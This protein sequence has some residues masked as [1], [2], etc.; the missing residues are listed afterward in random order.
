[1]AKKDYVVGEEVARR[2]GSRERVS[3]ARFSSSLATLA[4]EEAISMQISCKG[5]PCISSGALAFQALLCFSANPGTF[6]LLW[7]DPAQNLLAID[8]GHRQKWLFTVMINGKAAL[9]PQDA[10]LA[11]R[12]S[13]FLTVIPK[14]HF[15][16][17]Q[18]LFRLAGLRWKV[19]TVHD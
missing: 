5:L 7:H 2:E 11:N 16:T 18:Q 12:Y 19:N 10:M 6:R 13:Y 9:E 4:A 15:I 8:L 17:W 1:M 3:L 14:N